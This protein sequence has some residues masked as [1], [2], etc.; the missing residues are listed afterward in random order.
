[1][2]VLNADRGDATTTAITWKNLKDLKGQFQ[3]GYPLDLY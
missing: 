3:P 2:R 1:M